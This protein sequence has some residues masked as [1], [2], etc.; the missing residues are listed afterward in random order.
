M[1][2]KGSR[3]NKI[4]DFLAD[5]PINPLFAISYPSILVS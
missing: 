2:R 1:Q 3:M 4:N 5:N